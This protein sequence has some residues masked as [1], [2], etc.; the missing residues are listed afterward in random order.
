MLPDLILKLDYW[1]LAV[2]VT[3]QDGISTKRRPS[4]VGRC[5]RMLAHFRALDRDDD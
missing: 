2:E 4:A 1:I 3:H 5:L